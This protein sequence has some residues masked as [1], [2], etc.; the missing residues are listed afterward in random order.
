MKW[1]RLYSMLFCT[2]NLAAISIRAENP[3]ESYCSEQ[4]AFD[5]VLRNEIVLKGA[6]NINPRWHLILY[7]RRARQSKDNKKKNEILYGHKIS[8][9]KNR[10]TCIVC[11]YNTINMNNKAHARRRRSERENGRRASKIFQKGKKICS[12]AARA[13]EKKNQQQQC[14]TRTNSVELHRRTPKGLESILP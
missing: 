11:T 5:V 3:Y 7:T 10:N 8:P 6:P 2:S 13:K 4:V 1:R 14:S 12:L 9:A